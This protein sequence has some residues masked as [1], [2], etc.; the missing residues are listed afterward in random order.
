MTSDDR[1]FLNW[2]AM[3][4]AV[5]A[6]VLGFFALGR[7]GSS[8]EQAAGAGG[9]TGEASV[10][11][12]ELGALKFSPQHIM[13]PPGEVIVRITNTDSQVHNFSV[14]G[15][16]S[17]DLQP[18][19]SQDLEL[20]ELGVGVYPM[21]CE[22]PGHN[23]AGMNGNLHIVMNAEPGAYTGTDGGTDGGAVDHYHGFDSWEEMQTAMDDRALRFI[24]EEKGEF[25]GQPLEWTMSD[26]GMFGMVTAFIVEE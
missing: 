2:L 13:A 10:I 14:L 18:G 4:L 3:A 5:A 15:T 16:K 19:E 25:G 1:S 6:L 12:M 7:V 17:R 20:G 22:I 26:D 24:T 23:E 9:G 11:E 21:L 8:G